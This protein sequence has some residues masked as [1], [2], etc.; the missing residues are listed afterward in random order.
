MNAPDDRDQHRRSAMEFRLLA[1]VQVEEDGAPLALGTGRR[2]RTLL[3]LF[4]AHPNQSAAT[5]TLIDQRSAEDPPPTA[6]TALR[7]HPTRLRSRLHPARPR[8]PPG[9][10]P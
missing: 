4:L 9:G 5:D 7:P 8:R 2:L 3:A 6:P 1:P 10:P